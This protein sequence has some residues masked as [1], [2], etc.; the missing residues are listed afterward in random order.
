VTVISRTWPVYGTCALTSAYGLMKL[1][2]ALGASALVGTD[3]MRPDLRARLLARDPLFVAA[4]WVMFTAAVAGVLL[5]LAT[6]RPWGRVP[7]RLLVAV[8]MSIGALMVL[9]SLGPVGFGFV[10]DTLTLTGVRPPPAR[11]ATLSRYLALW[12]LTLWSPFFLLWG[13]TWLATGWRLHR[14]PQPT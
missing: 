10:G 1:A 14:T 12:D 8:T 13:L 5:A 4:H 6:L 11:Y 2:Q 3:P 9:R 7:R